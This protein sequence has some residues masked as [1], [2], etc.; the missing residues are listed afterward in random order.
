LLPGNSVASNSNFAAEK[1]QMI[2]SEVNGWKNRY[3]S[4]L[5]AAH[6]LGAIATYN[7]LHGLLTNPGDPTVS[8][9]LFDPPYAVITPPISMCPPEKLS[10]NSTFGNGCNILYSNLNNISKFSKNWTNGTT[11][12]AEKHVLFRD[13]PQ[14]LDDIKSWVDS[15]C[16]HL[17]FPKK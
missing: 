5:I 11:E 4:G 7:E 9:L 14:E 6:S 8:Y 1:K 2:R 15:S 10:L 17:T 13:E 16:K 3:L 12:P